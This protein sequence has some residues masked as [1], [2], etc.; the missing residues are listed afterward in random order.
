LDYIP[1]SLLTAGAKRGAG[2]IE[3]NWSAKIEYNYMDFGTER[4]A[5][6]A[7]SV[8]P[9]LTFAGS[10]FDI[11]TQVHA[12]KVGLNYRFGGF[13]KGPVAGKGPVVTRY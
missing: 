8:A 10:T 9:P 5:F 1:S 7:F 12:V 11:D 2:G 13:G 6:T 3:S 4:Y